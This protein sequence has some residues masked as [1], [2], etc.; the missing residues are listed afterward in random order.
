M[1]EKGGHNA[2]ERGIRRVKKKLRERRGRK[3]GR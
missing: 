3:K 2:E 1:T